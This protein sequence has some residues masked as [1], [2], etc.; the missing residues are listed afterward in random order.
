MH[1]YATIKGT[2]GVLPKK[3]LGRILRVEDDINSLYT[4]VL[5]QARAYRGTCPGPDDSAKNGP[6]HGLL[7][8]LVY[9]RREPKIDGTS[10]SPPKDAT[11]EVLEDALHQLKYRFQAM[12]MFDRYLKFVGIQGP[13]DQRCHEFDEK[14]FEHAH[15]MDDEWKKG[16]SGA[17]D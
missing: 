6:L 13:N 17:R 15:W 5:D 7:M 2:Q 11:W 4:L 8:D 16:W 1:E 9:H 10:S 14:R 12:E 3:T